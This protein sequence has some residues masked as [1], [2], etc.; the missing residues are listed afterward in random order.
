MSSW[1]VATSFQ[2][3][4]RDLGLRAKVHSS[5]M[6]CT[7]SALPS[8]RVPSLSRVA[9]TTSALKR[10]VTLGVALVELGL[11]DLD[12]GQ[13]DEGEVDLVAGGLAVGDGALEAVVDVLFEEV[14]QRLA[15][16]LAQRR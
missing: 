13:A 14:L 15:V 3:G 12:L 2:L 11:G 10:T 7:W 1:L 5:A 8:I 4:S 16:A 6:V 9:E